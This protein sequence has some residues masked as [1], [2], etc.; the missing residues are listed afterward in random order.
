MPVLPHFFNDLFP[1]TATLTTSLFY[2]LS[3]LKY[4]Y[5]GVMSALGVNKK[6]GYNLNL[7]GVT[8]PAS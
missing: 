2:V 3:V 8:N 4:I 5:V 7:N 1:S 6:G